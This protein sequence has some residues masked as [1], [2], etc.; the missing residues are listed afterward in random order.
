MLHQ[1]HRRPAA[2]RQR[3]RGPQKL[4]GT[5]VGPLL[6][7]LHGVD[8]LYVGE[9]LLGLLHVAVM[10]A[11]VRLGKVKAL[12]GIVRVSQGRQQHIPGK[13]L[14]GL[15]TP[16]VHAVDVDLLL[17]LQV[18]GHGVQRRER[19]AAFL[20]RLL[21]RHPPVLAVLELQHFGRVDADIPLLQPLCQDG[22]ALLRRRQ[23]RVDLQRPVQRPLGLVELIH[24][25]ED[26]A[27]AAPSELILRFV[28]QHGI[29]APQRLLVLAE[30]LEQGGLIEPGALVGAV[31]GDGASQRADRLLDLAQLGLDYAD[32]HPQDGVALFQLRRAGV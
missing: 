15:E 16:I 31:Q 32:V 24:P 6:R 5:L 3:H 9:D 2:G 29:E 27:L 17:G 4:L 25:H 11:H 21:P 26:A 14:V 8:L 7:E 19:K 1:P 22:A 30:L 23:G 18:L 12:P 20:E 28:G 10:H 13:G